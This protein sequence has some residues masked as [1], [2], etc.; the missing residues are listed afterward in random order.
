MEE[1]LEERLYIPEA[2]VRL[3]IKEDGE[4][5]GTSREVVQGS[6]Q[7]QR[8]IKDLLI[9]FDREVLGMLNLNSKCEVLNWSIVG[10]GD[11]ASCSFTGR[12]IL[13]CAILSNSA[14]VVLFHNHPSGDPVPS[15]EDFDS[16]RKICEACKLLG[17][18]LLDHIIVGSGTGRVVSLK[19]EYP[20]VF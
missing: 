9:D 13:K 6:Q 4:G 18:S 20:E 10:I 5:Y 11:L 15:A 3:V 14:G 7:A 17:I 1:R 8:F 19:E 2:C 12:E 16:T